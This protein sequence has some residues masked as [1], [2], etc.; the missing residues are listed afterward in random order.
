[1]RNRFELLVTDKATGRADAVRFDT[2][3]QA[4]RE[5]ARY[6]PTRGHRPFRVVIRDR[7]RDFQQSVVF[8]YE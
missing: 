7:V 4:Q 1:M 5:A 2:L 3:A 6:M 8:S